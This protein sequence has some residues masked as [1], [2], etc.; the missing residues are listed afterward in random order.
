MPVFMITSFPIRSGF[1]TASRSP[2]G[3]PQ[4]WTTTV[5]SRR[6]SSCASR[7]IERTWKS[8]E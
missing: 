2:I 8:Y 6:S 3:P 4:S 5:A 7:S 1:S